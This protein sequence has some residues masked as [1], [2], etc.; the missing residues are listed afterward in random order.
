MR[1][2]IG[3][4]WHE[5]SAQKAIMVEF[6]EADLRNVANMAPGA[7]FY[8]QFDPA[9]ERTPDEKLAWMREP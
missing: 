9:D 1:V 2:K 5:V 4:S 8:G 3:A 7:R 6:S